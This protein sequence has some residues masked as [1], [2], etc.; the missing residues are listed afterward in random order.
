[1]SLLAAMPPVDEW[2]IFSAIAETLLCVWPVFVAI[3]TRLEDILATRSNRAP[4]KA[5]ES[6]IG[7]ENRARRWVLVT[8]LQLVTVHLMIGRLRGV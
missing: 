8:E 7:A 1:M 4:Q 2:A 5:T 6:E 3:A